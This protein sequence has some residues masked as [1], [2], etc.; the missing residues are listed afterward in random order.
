MFSENGCCIY[1][2]K[3]DM[4]YEN[5]IKIHCVEYRIDMML[6]KHNEI[7]RIYIYGKRIQ[8]WYDNLCEYDCT[9]KTPEL[10][11]SISKALKSF[12]YK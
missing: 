11:N 12:I 10:F 7:S 4:V 9:N 2:G 1:I 3:N 6:L 5:Y 8:V